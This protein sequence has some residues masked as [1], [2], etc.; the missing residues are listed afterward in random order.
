MNN[1]Q[2][3][4]SI[5][6]L[7]AHLVVRDEKQLM[8]AKA[9]M[10][11]V[12]H[13]VEMACSR[14]RDDSEVMRLARTGAKA[15]PISPTLAMLVDGALQAA[16]ASDG[17]VDP[18]LGHDLVQL[19]YDRDIKELPQTTL[20]GVE[21]STR[22][23]RPIL[24]P[25][26]ALEGNKLTLPAGTALDLGATAKAMAADWVAARIAEELET[27]V[28]V[29]MG[30]DLATAGTDTDT[31]QVMVQDTDTDPA[32]QVT[33]QSGYALA[34]SS[35]QKRRWSNRGLP[36]HHI[37]D[38]AFGLPADPVWSSITV[39]AP[40]CM[41]ANT[42]STAGIVRGALAID[43]FESKHLAAR[44]VDASGQVHR[45]SRWP[46]PAIESSE[47]KGTVSLHG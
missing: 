3:S 13:E 36:M 32:Q 17:N 37:L 5:W 14:F 35:T 39:A 8:P 15:T 10:D 7:E 4:W 9:L 43:W 41:V 26:I 19:G 2:I 1:N 27:S 20:K 29:S 24:W 22:P 46:E 21:I 28:L 31:W 25:L 6:G 38:P 47:Q 45:T 11:S 23:L 16:N 18:L 40:T 12:L 33:L 30:G 42:Y 44:L 34:T